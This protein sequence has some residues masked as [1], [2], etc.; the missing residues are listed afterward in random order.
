MELFKVSRQTPR[1]FLTCIFQRSI[2]SPLPIAA[3]AACF[4]HTNRIELI[5]IE[6]VASQAAFCVRFDTPVA[7][8]IPLGSNRQRARKTLAT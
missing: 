6:R 5:L 2:V 7:L 4:L 3:S 8:G 1:V